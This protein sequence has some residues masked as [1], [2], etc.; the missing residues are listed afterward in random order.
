MG[1]RSRFR[2]GN[3][4]KISLP[5]SGIESR[6]SISD[7]L[8]LLYLQAYNDVNFNSIQNTQFLKFQTLSYV[9][10]CIIVNNFPG[11]LLSSFPGVTTHCGCIFTAQ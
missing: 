9:A 5:I 6:L 11:I 3:E 2:C 4:E 7:P 10:V 1:R 8:T